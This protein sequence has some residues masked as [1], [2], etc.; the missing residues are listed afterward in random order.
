MTGVL[1]MTAV[2]T[3][4]GLLR[5]GR[6]CRGAGSGETWNEKP[7]AD[8]VLKVMAHAPLG[9]LRRRVRT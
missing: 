2:K 6:D 5:Y 3:V 7:L 9:I 1:E 4:R 8:E